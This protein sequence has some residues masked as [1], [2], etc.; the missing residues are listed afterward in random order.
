M[1]VPAV[2]P[3]RGTAGTARAADALHSNEWLE[4][5][6]GFRNVRQLGT[7]KLM[8]RDFD[9]PHLL[10]HGSY[11]LGRQHGDSSTTSSRNSEKVALAV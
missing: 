5:I 11:Q 3:I 1:D 6:A 10:R 9:L 8:I 4:P 7:Y 2:H